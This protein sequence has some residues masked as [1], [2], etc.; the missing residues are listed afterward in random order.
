MTDVFDDRARKASMAEDLALL[1]L[2]G[3]GLNK[4]VSQMR[5]K[6]KDLT[7]TRGSLVALKRHPRYDEVITQNEESKIRRGRME[8]RI[9]VINLV[10]TF[11]KALERVLKSKAPAPGITVMAKVLYD[12]D[13][14]TKNQQAQQLQIIMPQGTNI[15]G[16]KPDDKK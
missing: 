11:L 14:E 1:E 9:G 2:N 6:Y 4:A 12:M 3:V 16:V 5:D 15:P 13:G 8:G 7:I 10:P